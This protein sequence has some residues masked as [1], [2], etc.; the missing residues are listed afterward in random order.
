MRWAADRGGGVLSLFRESS[1]VVGVT[2]EAREIREVGAI[3]TLGVVRTAAAVGL[4]FP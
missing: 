1:P 4:E 3:R 2:V